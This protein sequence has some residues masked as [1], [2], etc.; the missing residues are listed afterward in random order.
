MEKE[1]YIIKPGLPHSHTKNIYPQIFANWIPIEFD[2]LMQLE[3]K[4]GNKVPESFLLRMDPKTRLTDFVSQSSIKAWGLLISPKA[5]EII[6]KFKIQSN[7]EVYEAKIEFK[8]KIVDYF[9]LNPTRNYDSEINYEKTIFYKHYFLDDV[10]AAFKALDSKDLV[11]QLLDDTNVGN[12]Y[13]KEIFLYDKA[14]FEFDMFLIY[15]GV[16]AIVIS[17]EL[18][19]ALIDAGLTGFEVHQNPIIFR[20]TG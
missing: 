16:S 8:G 4:P 13:C 15:F 14:V 1:F 2:P 6:S 12:V 20:Y 5:Y 19:K 18:L 3:N 11:S 9:W 10:T 17:K 7:H